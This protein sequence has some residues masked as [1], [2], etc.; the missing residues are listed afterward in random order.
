MFHIL[1]EQAYVICLPTDVDLSN[2]YG[3][4]FNISTQILTNRVNGS[5]SGGVYSVP[6]CA[7]TLQVGPY[8]VTYTGLIS[9]TPTAFYID[10]LHNKM[11]IRLVKR[12]GGKKKTL[13]AAGA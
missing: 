3:F 2:P 5:Q 12:S 11:H 4:A 7:L 9:K 1:P 10:W 13:S 6:D 8:V